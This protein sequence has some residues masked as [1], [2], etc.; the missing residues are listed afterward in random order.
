MSKAVA[1][2]ARAKLDRLSRK[3][4]S[5]GVKS[6]DDLPDQ[7]F[8]FE[9]R[10]EMLRAVSACLKESEMREPPPKK[11]SPKEMEVALAYWRERVQKALAELSKRGPPSGRG[12]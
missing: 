11:L 2:I 10:W 6:L 1:S 12:A 4:D 8:A 3:F 5:F 7:K 9:F